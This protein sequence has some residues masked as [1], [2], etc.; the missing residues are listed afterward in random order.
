[1]FYE[2]EFGKEEKKINPPKSLFYAGVSKAA[3]ACKKEET[4]NCASLLNSALKKLKKK[5]RISPHCTHKRWQQLSYRTL[6]LAN[7][8]KYEK[9]LFTKEF[10]IRQ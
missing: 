2:A 10:F 3:R 9:S 8:I 6:L 4:K 7:E 5:E 1:M